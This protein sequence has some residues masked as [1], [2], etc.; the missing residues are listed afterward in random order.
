MDGI[1]VKRSF[2]GNRTLGFPLFS[3]IKADAG[4]R[5]NIDSG[6]VGLQF[7]IGA[8]GVGKLTADFLTTPL[9]AYKGSCGV[10]QG[11]NRGTAAAVHIADKGC[12]TC[13]SIA[14]GAVVDHKE[15]GAIK[16]ADIQT[17]YNIHFRPFPPVDVERPR[18][19]G[20]RSADRQGLDMLQPRSFLKLR[21]CIRISLYIRINFP[22]CPPP[23]LS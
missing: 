14:A 13:R 15:I 21:D 16:V 23:V 3:T 17:D 18:D 20:R 4:S 12:T 2:G 11:V 7:Q 19:L 1:D 10:E 22:K 6:G 9:K 8:V 5:Q